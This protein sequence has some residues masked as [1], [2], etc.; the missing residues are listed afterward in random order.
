[1][2]LGKDGEA[3][4][5]RIKFSDVLGLIGLAWVLALFYVYKRLHDVWHMERQHTERLVLILVFLCLASIG[6]SLYLFTFYRMRLNGGDWA[7]APGFLS[8]G[9]GGGL[10]LGQRGPSTSAPSPASAALAPWRI[11]RGLYDLTLGRLTSRNSGGVGPPLQQGGG[12][13]PLET[14][15]AAVQEMVSAPLAVA[16]Q[17]D[18]EVARHAL[19]AKVAKVSTLWFLLLFLTYRL[20]R[21]V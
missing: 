2:V 13:G 19:L 10:S 8:G 18:I 7:V 6:T 9:G 4:L 1:M 16:S 20:L 11:G 15:A 12:G 3:D 17:D 21:R 14:A 5:V